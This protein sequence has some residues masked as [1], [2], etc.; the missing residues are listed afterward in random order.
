MEPWQPPM[1]NYGYLA[2]PPPTNVDLCVTDAQPRPQ[3]AL[4]CSNQLVV[5][6]STGLGAQDG[7]DRYRTGAVVAAAAYLPVRDTGLWLYGCL[8]TNAAKL[9]FESVTDAN[10]NSGSHSSRRI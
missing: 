5:L 2:N 6:A 4:R 9:T 3:S 10:F 8:F 7:A 1:R